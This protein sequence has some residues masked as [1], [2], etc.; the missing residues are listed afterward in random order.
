MKT[1]AVVLLFGIV[2]FSGVSLAEPFPS[3][4]VDRDRGVHMDGDVHRDR[5]MRMDWDRDHDHDRN[6]HLHRFCMTAPCHR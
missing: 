6:R 1:L 4:R 2:A 3:G 5:N